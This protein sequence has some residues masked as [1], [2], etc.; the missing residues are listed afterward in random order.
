MADPHHIAETVGRVADAA[1]FL[2]GVAQTQPKLSGTRII[3]AVIIAGVIG[4]LS[5]A[6][7]TVVVIPQIRLE[8]QYAQRDT[9]RDVAYIRESVTALKEEVK[10]VKNKVEFLSATRR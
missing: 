10:E 9:Q 2:V 5:I 3:E 1:P 6:Y 7:N 8:Q 4:G